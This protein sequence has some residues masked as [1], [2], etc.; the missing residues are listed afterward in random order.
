MR[1]EGGG[2]RK[3]TKQR[4]TEE[5]I[6]KIILIKYFHLNSRGS[7]TKTNQKKQICEL[8]S[9][10]KQGDIDFYLMKKINKTQYNITEVLVFNIC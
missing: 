9:T 10:T 8:Y 3:G 4:K 6:I 5:A 1:K 7:F 2:G